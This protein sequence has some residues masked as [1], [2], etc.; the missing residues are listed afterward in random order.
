MK[1]HRGTNQCHIASDKI[2]EVRSNGRKVR[3]NGMKVR[4]NGRKVRSNGM[5]VRSNGRYDPMEWK[6]DRMEESYAMEH[7]Y[8]PM[9][10]KSRLDCIFVQNAPPYP[11]F[12]PSNTK[13]YQ[14]S[15]FK[16]NLT[17]HFIKYGKQI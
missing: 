14:I 11:F 10:C 12:Y 8:D 16:K 1:Y 15:K 17:F 9:E 2:I 6:Y 7:E 4:S 5:E 3:S 13:E